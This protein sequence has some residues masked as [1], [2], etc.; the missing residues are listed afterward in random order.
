MPPRT[1]ITISNVSRS[2]RYWLTPLSPAINSSIRTGTRT[3]APNNQRSILDRETIF[4]ACGVGSPNGTLPELNCDDHSAG[5]GAAFQLIQ[6]S[7]EIRKIP[8]LDRDRF[9]L[10]CACK[11]DDRFEFFDTAKMRALYRDSTQDC[12]CN[13]ERN[14]PAE[15]T[16]KNQSA[17]FSQ[18][19]DRKLSCFRGANEIDCAEERMVGNS[20]QLLLGITFARIQ[21]R[22]RARLFRRE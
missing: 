20:F 21:S 12:T 16:D 3:I 9:D 15:Q 2:T 1:I 18:R 13:R 14:L 22:C 7:V 5:H 4:T 6:C 11:R 10:A 19:A 8:L 17:A